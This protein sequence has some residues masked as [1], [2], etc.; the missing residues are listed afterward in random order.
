MHSS[1]HPNSTSGPGEAS[2]AC[3]SGW[4]LEG[5]EVD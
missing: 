2:T 1:G 5:F 3:D 4:V